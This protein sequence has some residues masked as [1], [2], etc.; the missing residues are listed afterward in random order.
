MSTKVYKSYN[1][2]SVPYIRDGQIV[3]YISF[4]EENY[5]Y[6]TSNVSMQNALESLPCFGSLFFLYREEHTDPLSESANST[7]VAKEYPDISDWQEA[8][9]ILRK[10]YSIPHQS[11]NTPGNILKKAKEAGIS[12]PNLKLTEKL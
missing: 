2:L 1:N 12:F 7:V 9:D 8:K 5:T 6:R 3:G 10:E 4:K 11:L